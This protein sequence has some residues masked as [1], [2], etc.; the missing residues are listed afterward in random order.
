VHKKNEV[1]IDVLE[2]VNLL[3]SSNGTLLRS[4]VSGQVMMKTF[5]TGMPDCKVWRL[6]CRCAA[7]VLCVCTAVGCHHRPLN[8]PWPPQFGLNDKIQMDR[9][10][11]AP[12]SSESG[13]AGAAGRRKPVKGVEVRGRVAVRAVECPF[14]VTGCPSLYGVPTSP[15]L[16]TA[17]SIAACNLA[18]SKL[19]GPLH[20][21]LPTA[22][23]SL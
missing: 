2:R 11:S 15:R 13:G 4:D 21:C 8:C 3:V 5:L 6:R 9:D 7:F 1:Y 16:T 12:A 20:S 14:D 23:L 10:G 22:S 18:N 17:P 19:I